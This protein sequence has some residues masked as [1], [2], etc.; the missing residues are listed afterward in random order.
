MCARLIFVVMLS[1]SRG[2]GMV[3]ATL[4]GM[5]RVVANHCVICNMQYFYTINSCTKTP[6]IICV[7]KEIESGN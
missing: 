1:L 2:G 4:I 7:Q 5:P 6:R 3:I